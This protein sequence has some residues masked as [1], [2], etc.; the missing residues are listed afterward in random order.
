MGS[1]P[2]E[3]KFCHQAA[4]QGETAAQYQLGLCYANG[5]GVGRDL[6]Q[7]ARWYDKAAKSGHADAASRLNVILLHNQS[8]W[9]RRC[10]KA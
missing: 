10:L 9:L 4:E 3:I 1:S 2:Q 8:S 6:S 5:R 7:A